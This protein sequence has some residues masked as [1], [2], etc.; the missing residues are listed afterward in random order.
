MLDT[1]NHLAAS[2]EAPTFPFSEVGFI[3][4]GSGW[5]LEGHAVAILKKQPLDS[6]LLRDTFSTGDVFASDLGVEV[7]YELLAPGSELHLLIHKGRSLFTLVLADGG[8]KLRLL[9]AD[10][11]NDQTEVLLE[12][13]ISPPRP[14][15][16]AFFTLANRAVIF[17]IDGQPQIDGVPYQLSIPP[18]LSDGPL[19]LP[20]FELVG[21]GG[22]GPLILG[23]LRLGRDISYR[24]TGTWGGAKAFQLAD[25]EYFLIGDNPSQSRDSRNYGAVSS[26]RILGTVA[27]RAWPLGWT[28]KGWAHD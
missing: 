12:Q 22:V 20:T 1:A 2:S 15:G 9:R 18:P 28:E 25:D 3:H 26:D 19:D 17:A 24:S 6:Y 13:E 11:P 10:Q 23:R 21:I 16:S 5:K 8:S 27:Y 7:A 14:R 4:Q